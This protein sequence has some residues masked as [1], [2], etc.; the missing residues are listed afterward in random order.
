LGKNNG[1]IKNTSRK[2]TIL[3]FIIFVNGCQ[4]WVGSI[5]NLWKSIAVRAPEQKN[6]MEGC[7]TNVARG[8]DDDAIILL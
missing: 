8:Q 5:Y 1:I 3:M 2:I 4:P 6:K 7:L